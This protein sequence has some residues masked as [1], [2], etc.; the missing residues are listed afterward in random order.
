MIFSPNLLNFLSHIFEHFLKS[1]LLRVRLEVVDVLSRVSRIPPFCVC[2]CC[3][4]DISSNP[5]TV[6]EDAF[7]AM[8][9]SLIVPLNALYYFLLVWE[10]VEIKSSVVTIQ[11]RLDKMTYNQFW[12]RCCGT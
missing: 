4:F 11:L 6:D 12:N 9:L 8:K 3:V 5:F 7:C 2:V 10:V 1:F